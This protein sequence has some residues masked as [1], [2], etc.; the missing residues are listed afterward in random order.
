MF[1]DV[2][3]DRILRGDQLHLV[4]KL[5]AFGTNVSLLANFFQCPWTEPIPTLSPDDQSWVIRHAGW[6]LRTL[7]RLK[8]AVDSLSIGAEEEDLRRGAWDSAL[9]A[10]SSLSFLYLLLGN[11]K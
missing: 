11:A 10:H 5:G 1:R 9:D 2:Y 7:G 6:S 8:D 4:S 3:R